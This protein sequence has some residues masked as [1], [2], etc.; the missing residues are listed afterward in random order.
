M[1]ST[2]YVDMSSTPVPPRAPSPDDV[3]VRGLLAGLEALIREPRRVM[4]QLSGP[5]AGA[6]VRN[7][8]IAAALCYLFYGVVAGTYAR[9]TQ[10]WAAPVKIA[11]GLVFSALICLP[12]LYIFAC[13]A[14]VRARLVEVAG[15]VAGLTAI[16]A[17]LLVGFAPVALVF[18]T[19]T[20]SL[21]AMGALH[22]VFGL[23]AYFFGARFLSAGFTHFKAVSRAGLKFW[24][25]LFLLVALQMTTALRP[26]IGTSDTILPKE[27]KFFLVHWTDCVK[28]AV[29]KETVK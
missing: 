3:P 28:E 17:L 16:L 27:K 2:A 24:M 13:L 5:R 1:E 15:L 20:D 10:L 4:V 29:D 23:V 18:S 7:M 6:L 26:I 22:I 19:S 11:G 9:G 8:F 25:I 14:G 21:P 12:S